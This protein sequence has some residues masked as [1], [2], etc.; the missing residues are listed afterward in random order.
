MDPTLIEVAV[1]EKIE[2]NDREKE[3]FAFFL[4]FVNAKDVKVVMRSAGG[5]VRDK[6]NIYLGFKNDFVYINDYNYY[7]F[8][9][10]SFA[11]NVMI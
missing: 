9:V 5:W 3:L 10:S 7:S 6:V 8:I 2:L 11:K 4:D 1:K